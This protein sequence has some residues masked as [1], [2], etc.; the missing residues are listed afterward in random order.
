M[1]I[2]TDAQ[3]KSMFDAI[4]L[5]LIA[6]SCIWNVLLFA[7]P[8]DESTKQYKVITIINIFVEGMFWTDFFLTFVQAYKDK[9]TLEEIID[10][11]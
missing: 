5:I 6:Y 10:L 7:F 3:W 8:I 2:P 9:E 1:I 4:V 11:K